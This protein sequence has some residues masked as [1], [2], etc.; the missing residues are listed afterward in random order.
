LSA[1][2]KT[3]QAEST[4]AILERGQTIH[5]A[6]SVALLHAPGIIRRFLGTADSDATAA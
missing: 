4:A 5:Q 1:V 2:R 6:M 3:V